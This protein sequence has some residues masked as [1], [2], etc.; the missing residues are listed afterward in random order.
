MAYV[1]PDS[2]ESE[3][4]FAEIRGVLDSLPYTAPECRAAK[5]GEIIDALALAGWLRDGVA[6]QSEPLPFGL[7]I[8]LGVLP[9]NEEYKPAPGFGYAVIEMA[10]EDLR[11]APLYRAVEL[12]E[13][14]GSAERRA[15]DDR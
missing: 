1:K 6:L 4:V 9:G 8:S 14:A 15:T 2:P 3:A 12:R 13:V 5:V 11:R 10:V 7:L